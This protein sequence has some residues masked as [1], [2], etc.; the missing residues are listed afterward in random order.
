MKNVLAPL[1]LGII[2]AS[3]ILRTFQPTC[4]LVIST[5]SAPEFHYSGAFFSF[6]MK[7]QEQHIYHGAALTQIVHHETF[8]ALNRGSPEYGHYQVNADRHLFVKYRTNN[9]PKWT[10]TYSLD[11]IRCIRDAT[12]SSLKV[13]IVL[14]CG[15][16]T[17]CALSED[18]FKQILNIDNPTAQQQ[19]TVTVPKGGGCHVNGSNG[20]LKGVVTHNS[21]PGKVF[22]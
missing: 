5:D 1:G 12:I 7:T 8:K 14:T 22:E 10:F 15:Q 3:L 4:L 9:G 11:D 13:F 2:L 21:Y 20:K 17:I 18:Q 16:E 6:P 19:I